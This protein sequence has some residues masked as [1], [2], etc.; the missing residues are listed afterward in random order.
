MKVDD[1]GNFKDSLKNESNYSRLFGNPESVAQ[2]I[3]D[4]CE[5][6]DYCGGC[7]AQSAECKFG[8]YDALL[9]W[10]KGDTN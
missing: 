9:D 4:N 2:L 1:F 8:D 10:L 3:S 7:L 5:F 6:L